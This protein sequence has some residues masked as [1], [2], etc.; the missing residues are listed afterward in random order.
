MPGERDGHGRRA[1]RRASPRPPVAPVVGWL[2]FTLV[3]TAVVLVVVGLDTTTVAWLVGAG[4]LV[5]AV[6][7]AAVL[8]SP[9]GTQ[10]PA[11]PPQREGPGAPDDDGVGDPP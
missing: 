1:R 2:V 6:L 9:P 8:L 3:M 11:P 5:G 7:V 4:A 10:G